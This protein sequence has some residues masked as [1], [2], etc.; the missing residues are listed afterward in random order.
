VPLYLGLDSS[1]QSLTAIVIAFDDGRRQVVF[2]SSLAFDETLPQYGTTHGVL[3]RSDPHVATSSP[4]MWAEALELM[5]A[6]LAA[7]G[8]DLTQLAA[9]SG[10]AQ[11]HGSV[12]LNA[13][14]ARAVGTLEPAR[15]LADQLRHI[16]ARDESPI[17]MDSSTAD[18]CAEITAAVGGARVLAQRTGSRAFERFTGPQIRR[19][20][21]Q[22]PERYQATT[23]VHLVSSFLASLLCGDDAP[24]DPGDASG[25]NLM[26]LVSQDWWDEAVRATAPD[27]REKLPRIAPS[28][29]V[30]GRLSPYWQARYGLPAAQVVAWSGDNPCSLIGTGLV[31]EGRV[32]ISLGTSD[33][34]FGL[35]REPRV[36]PTGTGHVFGAPTGDYMGLTCF[37][38]G[39]LARER[40]RNE[41]GMTWVAFS[42]ALDVT[43]PAARIVLPWYEPE[44]TP[45]VPVAGVRRYGFSASDPHAEVRALVDAQMMSMALHSRWMGVDIDTIRATGGAAANRAILQTMADVFGAVVYQLEVANSAALG[46]A[47]RAAHADISAGDSS[48]ST[49]LRAGCD[50]DDVVEGFVEPI[51]ATRLEPDGGRHDFYGSLIQLYAACEAHALGRGPDPEPLLRQLRMTSGAATHTGSG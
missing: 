8:L 33:T 51:A 40:V 29:T 7:S 31:K 17:W 23:R 16:L 44:I 3:P 46:A 34:V 13:T 38:N 14:W 25:M 2:E 9:I 49:S 42:H 19:F 32:A 47:L 28:S 4:L 20:S 35:M 48:L 37:L 21:K 6:R 22:S 45:A 18:E 43:P 39:S 1:T 26:D 12:Y 27:L 11:Q 15:T 5:L 30:V 50:W 24:I 36:D 10:S 41:L